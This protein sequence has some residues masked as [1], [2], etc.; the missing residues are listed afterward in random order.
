ME[1]VQIKFF[2]MNENV[3]LPTRTHDGDACWDIYANEKMTIEP[4]QVVLVP[5]GLKSELPIGWELQIRPRS[6][7]AAKFGLNVIFGTVDAGYRGEIKVVL[8]NTSNKPFSFE[9]GYKVAQIAFKQVHDV[10]II[11]VE[12]ESLLGESER[13]KGGFGSTG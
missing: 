3:K 12:S 13:G 4:N 6:G 7:N 1:E 2:R 5:I 9:I 8:H 10:K 11:E